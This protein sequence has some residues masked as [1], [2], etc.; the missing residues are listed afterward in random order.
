M[1]TGNKGFDLKKP[2]LMLSAAVI[3]LGAVPAA[4]DD[5]TDITTGVTV[6]VDTAHAANGSPGD[7]KLDTAGS[8]TVSKSGTQTTPQPAVTI[9]SNN[10]FD[11]IAGTTISNKDTDQAAGILVDLTTQNLDATNTNCP[12]CHTVEGIVTAGT[13]DL[14]GT[15]T[16]KRGLWL[17]GPT[18]GDPFTFTGNIEMIGS[19]MTITGDNSVGVL[20]DALA[21][22]N[23][24]LTLGSM[25]IQPSST[26]SSAAIYG[27]ELNGVVNGNVQVGELNSDGTTYTSAAVAV[28]AN[29]GSGGVIAMDLTGTINGNVIIN[30]NSSISAVGQAV[31]GVVLTGNIDACNTSGCTS[32]GSFVNNGSITVAGSSAALVNPTGN[33]E[34]GIAV[35]IEGNVAGGIYNGGPLSVSDTTDTVATIS[36]RANTEALFITQSPN[37][38]TSPLVVGVY[39]G[40]VTNPGFSFYNRGSITASPAN[41][42]DNAIDIQ[43]F[44]N[45]STA[46]TTLTEGIYSSGTISAAAGSSKGTPAVVATA[47]LVGSYADVGPSDTYTVN[48][49]SDG[50]YSVTYNN[51]GSGKADQAAFVNSAATGFGRITATV[52]GPTVG[53][54]AQAFVISPNAVMPSLIN[55]GTISAAAT[56]T[57]L[58]NTG[59]DALDAFAL[60]DKSGTLTYIQNN[61]TISAVAT[62]LNDNSQKAIAID[63]SA[64]ST[65]TPSANGV[66]IRDWASTTTKAQIIGDILF[67]TGDNQILDV[68]G[69]SSD[70]PA[71][72]T[73]N[74]SYGGGTSNGVFGSDKL[75]IQNFA[76]VT[77]TITSKNGV[78]VDIQNGGT[79]TLTN[80][81]TALLANAFH[82]ENGGTLNVTVLNDFTSGII[83]AQNS[84][85]PDGVVNFDSGAKLNITYG[86][87][88][89]AESGFI[90]ITAPTNQLH[91][92]D[93]ATYNAQLAANLPFLFQ[94]SVL[95]IQ[96][97]ANNP[98][99]DD[100]LLTVDPKTAQELGLT[101]YAAQM[102]PY[103]NQALVNDDVLGAAMVAG[104]TN[105]ETAQRAYNQFA[106]DVSGGVRAIAISLTDQ[107]SGP[108]ASRQRTLRMYGKQDGEITLWGQEFAEYMTDPG[109]V[110]TGQTGFKDHGF[111][112]V[113]GLDGGEPKTGWYGGAFSFYSGDVV[114]P[115]PRDSHSNTLWYML[116]G[117][118]DWRGR[119]LFLDT[120]LDVGYMDIKEK[121][122]LNLSIPNSS[123]GTTAF[124]DEA[125]S[126]RPGL[127]GSGGFTTGAI[128]AYGST[129]LTPQFSFDGMT[130][131]EEGYT[132]THVGKNNGNGMGFNLHAQSYYASSLRAFLGTE[133]R[134]D[135]NLGDFFVQPD[136]RLGYRYDFLNDPAKL[137]VNFADLG[138]NVT[139]P[140][141]T[142]IGPDPAQGNFV[143][144]ASL[145]ATTDA[146]TIGANFDFVRGTNGATTEVGIIHLL[147]RI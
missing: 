63:L 75:T 16:T 107:A 67:G 103:A 1:A 140:V 130:M 89:P 109:K 43:I 53:G 27:V 25:T 119:G 36:T 90:L 102:L 54:R 5:W 81:D 137:K 132:E 24:N 146:W 93:L 17:E 71:T 82:V 60:T 7:I 101:G 124:V 40:D 121:R 122:F 13:I 97:D 15:G 139:P 4:A 143:A 117:Y 73:G 72:V 30:R 147:G 120:K 31:R 50:G 131:R 91:V 70:N 106:P 118:T 133:I 84:T 19:T 20:E 113:L 128:F 88:V 46:T 35:S 79:L 141:F 56:T 23:G 48:N 98:G 115:A 32:L 127:V 9:N 34:A 37:A 144:G 138:P 95:T 65:G 52:S 22:L 57:V 74:I 51:P 112:F 26:S 29:A 66:V 108:V 76:T 49:V 77:G 12:G 28:K 42:G 38:L 96:P 94:S 87:F 125:D 69:L 99:N 3:A 18:T 116:T 44:G 45:S 104:I 135:L 111:G 39:S 41:Q 33:T 83:T 11:Q 136:L 14:S 145:S 6:P 61:G 114:E 78:D 142:V 134:E 85:N 10:S 129:V 58:T 64:D 2:V 86:S 92:A 110:S 105:Q 8:I 59:S 21:T 126:K 123:G 68:M 47:M 100:L 62:P 80:K 55:S